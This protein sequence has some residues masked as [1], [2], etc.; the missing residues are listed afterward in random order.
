MK[1]IPLLE[2]Q[3]SAVKNILTTAYCEQSRRGHALKEPKFL[4][5]LPNHQF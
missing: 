3:I 1:N 2:E 4:Q 5:L